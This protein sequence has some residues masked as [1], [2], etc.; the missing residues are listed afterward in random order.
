MSKLLLFYPEHDLALAAGNSNYTAPAAALKLRRAGMA[1]PLWLGMAGDMVCTG[2]LPA[3][4]YGRVQAIFNL[5]AQP[6]DHSRRPELEAAPWGWSIPACKTLTEQGYDPSRLPGRQQLEAI[7]QLSH[8]RSAA[9]LHQMLTDRLSF[10]ILPG[11][12]EVTDINSVATDLIAKAPWSSSG[13]GLLDSRFYPP[14]DFVR[15]ATGM[16][17]R[18]GSVMIEPAYERVLDFALLYETDGQGGCEFAGHSV[19][20]TEGQGQYK[21][22]ILASDSALRDRIAAYVGDAHL[23]ELTRVVAECLGQ[24]TDGI[25][26]GPLGV[27]MLIARLPEGLDAAGVNADFALTQSYGLHATVEINFRSTMGLVARRLY[28]NYIQPGREGRY[29]IRPEQ[30]TD[31]Q[32]LEACTISDHR[33][34]SGTLILNPPA[35]GLSFVAEVG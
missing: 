23:A 21:A 17:R 4:W 3:E 8:R 15:F 16:V 22:N 27:D 11:A 6:Y 33:L 14:E 31:S 1:L 25:Y 32:L 7:R 29:Y 9:R 34:V 26:R 13:R 19:F 12:E 28:D 35:T 2:A 20:E 10:A 18:Q 24:M 5:Q 30:P